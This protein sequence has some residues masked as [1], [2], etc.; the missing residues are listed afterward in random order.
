MKR[1]GEVDRPTAGR[2]MVEGEGISAALDTERDMPLSPPMRVAA[3]TERDMPPDMSE[4]ETNAGKTGIDAAGAND[5]FC[6]IS[7]ISPC[8]CSPRR[9]WIARIVWE[10]A[11]GAV[12]NLPRELEVRMPRTSVG[13]SKGMDREAAADDDDEVLNS[14]SCFFLLSFDFFFA[15]SFVEDAADANADL[16]KND[17]DDTRQA[18]REH[19]SATAA[20]ISA[21]DTKGIDDLRFCACCWPPPLLL[22]S[23]LTDICNE[24]LEPGPDPDA[25]A[26]VFVFVLALAFPAKI[27]AKPAMD[28]RL[29]LRRVDIRLSVGAPLSEELDVATRLCRLD[30]EV[31]VEPAADAAARRASCSASSA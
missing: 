6:S 21:A 22:P 2:V 8:P 15:L 5:I 24:D 26:F 20:S 11:R 10:M 18:D 7:F 9:C 29:V 27:A 4:D 14:A 19:A 3:E 17:V 30:G 12:C 16:P 25:L 23:S 13:D 31:T 28:S 1:E